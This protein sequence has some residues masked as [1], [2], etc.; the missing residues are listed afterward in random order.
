MPGQGMSERVMG[1]NFPQDNRSVPSTRGQRLPVRTEGYAEYQFIL[2][3]RMGAR[4]GGQTPKRRLE[5]DN[6]GHTQPSRKRNYWQR[7]LG[8]GCPQASMGGDS[9]QD[10]GLV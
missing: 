2:T 5:A 8:E 3:V 9:P 1:L 10:D 6:K 4:R 7:V